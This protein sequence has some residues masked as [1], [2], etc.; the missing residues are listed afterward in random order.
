VGVG[1]RALAWQQGAP[2]GGRAGEDAHVGDGVPGRKRG[3]G[4]APVVGVG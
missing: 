2:G 3:K 4:T 1:R